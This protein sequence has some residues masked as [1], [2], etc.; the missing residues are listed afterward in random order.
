MLQ[1]FITGFREWLLE[2]KRTGWALFFVLLG[3]LFIS[4]GGREILAQQAGVLAWKLVLVGT[5]I[6][7]SHV[8]RKQLFP[9]ID[10]S[11]HIQNGDAAGGQIFLG[12]CVL[13]SAIIWALGAGL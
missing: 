13:T 11:S 10:L 1:K 8:A 3:G 4:D 12:I 9:Y 5:G 2:M 6:F 7:V